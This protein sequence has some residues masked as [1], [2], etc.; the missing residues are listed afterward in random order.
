MPVLGLGLFA[1]GAYGAWSQFSHVKVRVSTWL[2]PWAD[3]ADS[4]FQVIQSQFA[5]AWG[6][7]GGTGL[8]LGQST[9]TK[10]P[11]STTDMIFAVIGEE[12]GLFGSVAVLSAFLLIVGSGLRIAIST[13]DPYKKLLATGLTSLVAFQAFIIVAGVTRLLPLTG[14][15]LPFVSYGGSSLLANWV[16]IA[17]LFRISDSAAQEVAAAKTKVGFGA[18]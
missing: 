9:A 13:A 16:L 8:G 5:M 6:G 17:L 3:P 7:L 10:P 2:D 18:Q 12:L 15:T 11:Y 14:V 1:V 4:G